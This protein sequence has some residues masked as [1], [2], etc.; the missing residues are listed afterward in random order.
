MS[1]LLLVM[2]D[3]DFMRIILF[4]VGLH[5]RPSRIKLQLWTFIFILLSLKRPINSI[6][7][8]PGLPKTVYFK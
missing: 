8:D 6:Q 1:A 3:E 7:T 2:R 4:M 5:V